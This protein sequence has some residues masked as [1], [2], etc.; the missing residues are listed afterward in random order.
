MSSSTQRWLLW[1]L[2]FLVVA[3]ALTYFNWPKPI[4][5]QTVKV[6][7]A[8]V[9]DTVANT[10]VGS[11]EACN[12]SRISPSIGGQVSRLFVDEGDSVSQGQVLLE[13][14]NEDRKAAL[15]Q[16]EAGLNF[17]KADQA[18]LCLTADAAEREAKRTKQLEAKNLTSEERLDQTQ[19]QAMASRAACDSAKARTQEAE[20][21]IELAVASL[22][23][24]YLTAPFAGIVAEVT[25]E[26]GE[27][28]TPSPPG[29]ATP[30]AIDLLTNDCHYVIAPIDE[31]DAASLAVDMPVRVTMDAFGNR[32]FPG[33][34]RRVAAY[35]LDIAKQ[36]R[37]VDIEVAFDEA[38]HQKEFIAGYSADVEV[39]LAVRENALRLPTEAIR[40]GQWAWILNEDGI[41]EQRDI[42][43]GISNWQFTEIV[44]GL[45]E[46]ETV[47]LALGRDDIQLGM[48]AV[49]SNN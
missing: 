35:V 49:S 45:S 12:R 27:F 17:A 32:E 26:V 10:R 29:V 5:V 25:G 11:L 48:S 13:L 19:T 24:T 15:R 40:D 22:A 31:V 20:A 2:I 39:I 36:A 14:W 44:E 46:G 7:R 37:T 4:T 47:V 42:K 18:R 33:T 3:S 28:T 16:V 1:G 41:I 38:S 9:E 6:E 8:L 30:P 21:R 34:I 23:Q 43:T